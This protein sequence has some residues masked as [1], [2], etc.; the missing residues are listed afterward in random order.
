MEEVG[1]TELR[2]MINMIKTRLSSDKREAAIG[3]LVCGCEEVIQPPHTSSC[4]QCHSI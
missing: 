1:V 4:Q 2:G 3:L